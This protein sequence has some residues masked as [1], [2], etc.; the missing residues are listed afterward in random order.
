[1]S[2]LVS[3]KKFKI[4]SQVGREWPN[5]WGSSKESK[6][7]GGPI[8]AEASQLSLNWWGNHT[9]KDVQ[10]VRTAPGQRGC[11]QPCPKHEGF[12]NFREITQTAKPTGPVEW[13]TSGWAGGVMSWYGMG[14]STYILSK[15]LGQWVVDPSLESSDLRTES[16]GHKPYPNLFTTLPQDHRI[17][18]NCLHSPAL[19]ENL[20][21]L[22]LR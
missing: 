4:P 6:R 20:A 13:V 21:Q 3:N 18:G 14:S 10:R 11:P 2:V 9:P 22:S 5:P 12:P 16:T 1:M 17:L 19:E 8:L 7:T 15:N